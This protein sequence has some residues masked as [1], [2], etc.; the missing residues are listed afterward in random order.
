[1]PET[2][3]GDVLVPLLVACWSSAPLATIPLYSATTARSDADTV[4]LM[5]N[6][7]R[8]LGDAEALDAYHNSRSSPPVSTRRSTSCQ[9]L[10]LL[11]LTVALA[12]P[13]PIR[14]AATSRSPAATGLVYATAPTLPDV[15]S[16]VV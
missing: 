2:T 5:L 4:E 15:F 11:S 14:T 8:A 12:V 7:G 1:V 3:T 9:V 13:L 10:P 16:T 6:V